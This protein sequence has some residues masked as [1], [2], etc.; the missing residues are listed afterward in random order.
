MISSTLLTGDPSR[1]SSVKQRNNQYL[2][3]D[4]LRVVGVGSC[5]LDYLAQVAAW[6]K[7]DDKLRTESLEVAPIHVC[8]LL[9]KL[10]VL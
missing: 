7:P 2:T 1:R 5:G 3:Q 4:V 9:N 10:L 6:P 8:Y